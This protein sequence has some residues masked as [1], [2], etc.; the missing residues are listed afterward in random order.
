[1]YPK[2]QQLY[3]L[4][5]T[6]EKCLHTLTRSTIYK[7]Q[8]QNQAKKKKKAN[9]HK[10]SNL[11]AKQMPITSRRDKHIL[12]PS[13]NKALIIWEKNHKLVTTIYM[14]SGM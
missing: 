8:K 9:N 3:S 11:E 1:M 7:Y 14:N 13:R 10:N 4:V 2:I 5:Y 12:M 6:L